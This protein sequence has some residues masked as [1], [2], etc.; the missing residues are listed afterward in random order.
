M[1]ALLQISWESIMAD[2]PIFYIG[3]S[4]ISVKTKDME[5]LFWVII[6]I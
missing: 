4:Q 1:E 5:C 3:S 2:L 6:Y